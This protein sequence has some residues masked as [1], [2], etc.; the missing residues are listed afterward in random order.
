MHPIARREGFVVRPLGPDVVVLGPDRTVHR[1]DAVAGWVY[2][3]ADGQRDVASLAMGLRADV[4]ANADTAVVFEALDLLAD[5]GLLAARVAPPS[6]VSRRSMLQRLSGAAAIAALS[7]VVSRPA[8][9][10]AGGICAEDKEIIDAIAELEAIEGAVAEVLDQWVEDA[11]D[12]EKADEFYL[13]RLG[14]TER[15]HKRRHQAL[16]YKL[17]L[18]TDDLADCKLDATAAN[19]VAEKRAKMAQQQSKVRQEA[20]AK[21]AVKTKEHAHKRRAVQVNNEE[22]RKQQLLQ[23]EEN[24]K[25]VLRKKKIGEAQQEASMKASYKQYELAREELEKRDKTRE[26]TLLAREEQMKKQLAELQKDAEVRYESKAK[27]IDGQLLQS[28]ERSKLFADSYAE[29]QSEAA[30]KDAGVIDRA[31]EIAQEEAMKAAELALQDRQQEE[32]QKSIELKKEQIGKE[33]EKK[34]STASET[35]AKQ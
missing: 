9:A 8:F 21:H 1:L 35:K 18:A 16:A 11:A 32:G 5:A 20:L 4:D 29:R 23:T 31:M 24:Q 12:S 13:A 7:A 33:A 17:D 28:E 34:S 15:E 30:S 25:D 19:F 6:G 3:H 22:K 10:A 27:N 2:Q 14:K 26:M